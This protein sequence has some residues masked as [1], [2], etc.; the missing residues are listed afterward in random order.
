MAKK[1]PKPAKNKPATTVTL[2]PHVIEMLLVAVSRSPHLNGADRATVTAA[3][4]KLRH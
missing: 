2:T 4:H 3:L 1:K